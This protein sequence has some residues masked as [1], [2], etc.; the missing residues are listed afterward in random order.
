MENT[1]SVL[2]PNPSME[3]I[4]ASASQYLEGEIAAAAFR[5]KLL[6]VIAHVDQGALIALAKAIAD[7][8][9]ETD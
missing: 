4:A 5:D 8:A 6:H 1:M 2:M 9:E 3:E 7:N